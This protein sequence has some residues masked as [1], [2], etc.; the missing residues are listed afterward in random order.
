MQQLKSL[1]DIAS[2]YILLK[3]T[4]SKNISWVNIPHTI[5]V[6]NLKQKKNWEILN[7]FF[8]F[9]CVIDTAET[10]FGDFRRD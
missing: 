5:Q 7:Y 1:Y 2:P 8:G 9:S 6:Q 4:S 10:D 3:R